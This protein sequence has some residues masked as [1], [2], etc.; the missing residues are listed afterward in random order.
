[1]LGRAK[2]MFCSKEHEDAHAELQSQAVERLMTA[3]EGAQTKGTREPADP[4]SELERVDL[5][6]AA[7]TAQLQD[8]ARPLATVANLKGVAPRPT[9][10]PMTPAYPRF[11][12]AD[13]I[14]VPISASEIASPDSFRRPNCTFV[15]DL[16]N[17]LLPAELLALL[18]PALED[19]PVFLLRGPDPAVPPVP[20]VAESS[21]VRPEPP[22]SIQL[23]SHAADVSTRTLPTGRPIRIDAPPNRGRVTVRSGSSCLDTSST[24]LP[25][26]AAITLSLEMAAA[27]CCKEWLR[28][29]GAPMPAPKRREQDWAESEIEIEFPARRIE[30]PASFLSLAASVELE[31]S[32]AKGR[33][34]VRTVEPLEM[35]ADPQFPSTPAVCPVLRGGARRPIEPAAAWRGPTVSRTE[36]ILP[37]QPSVENGI[38]FPP[39][40]SAPESEPATPEFAISRMIGSPIGPRA[41]D[42]MTDVP[43]VLLVLRRRAA[44][45]K[46]HGS[47]RLPGFKPIPMNALP[48]VAGFV[49]SIEPLRLARAMVAVAG[50]GQAR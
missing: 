16:R 47:S 14:R 21:P 24:V 4:F 8:S 9:P 23:P 33:A 30:T 10:P 35:L 6:P 27:I 7:M 46:G 25:T 49:S 29:T 41:T 40:I 45:E 44:E 13:E 3:K 38:R 37:G 15:S 1:M 48:A 39:L 34:T 22:S 12:L 32:C 31:K 50:R 18:A 11:A 43:A 28:F 42:C 17:P 5:A 2:G 26:G 20:L 36:G 19:L